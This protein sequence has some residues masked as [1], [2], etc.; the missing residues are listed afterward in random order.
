M[1]DLLSALA[2][3]FVIEGIL[4]FAAPGK[5]KESLRMLEGMSDGALRMVGLASMTIGLIVLSIVR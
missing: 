3:V 5:L 2:L 4:P 1:Q